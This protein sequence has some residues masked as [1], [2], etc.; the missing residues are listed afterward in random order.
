MI[1]ILQHITYDEYLPTLLGKALPPYTGYNDQLF[2]NVEN[3]F[4]SVAMRFAHS[5]IVRN[6]NLIDEDNKTVGNMDLKKNIFQS[7]YLWNGVESKHII[8]GMCNT[9]EKQTNI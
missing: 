4:S 8:L 5:N 1:A 6:I 2:P 9:P 7:S 3:F